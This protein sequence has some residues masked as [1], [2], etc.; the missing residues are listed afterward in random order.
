MAGNKDRELASAKD[1]GRVDSPIFKRHVGKA[2]DMCS[3]S[4]RGDRREG[5]LH[6]ILRN[7]MYPTIREARSQV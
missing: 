5:M 1:D 3:E 7:S 4:S 2:V 6:E